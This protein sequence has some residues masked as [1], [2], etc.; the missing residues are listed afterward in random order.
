MS[1]AHNTDNRERDNGG[2]VSP[3]VPA[4]QIGATPINTGDEWSFST[5]HMQNKDSGFATVQMVLDA[6]LTP[7]QRRAA[8]EAARGYHRREPG[9]SASPMRMAL[10]MYGDVLPDLAG[11]EITNGVLVPTSRRTYAERRGDTPVATMRDDVVFP[12][13]AGSELRPGRPAGGLV[14]EDDAY[15]NQPP[16]SFWDTRD[17]TPPSQ[18]SGSSGSGSSAA[19]DFYEQAKNIRAEFGLTEHE[20]NTIRWAE[21]MANGMTPDE[22]RDGIRQRLSDREEA[23]DDAQPAVLRGAHGF[24]RDPNVMA[25]QVIVRWINEETGQVFNAPDPSWSPPN[26]DWRRDRQVSAPARTTAPTNPIGSSGSSGSGSSGSSG[27]TIRRDASNLSPAAQR[28]Q[29]IGRRMRQNAAERNQQRTSMPGGVNAG[30]LSPP[31]DNS[32]PTPGNI[33][34]ATTNNQH[35]GGILPRT[36]G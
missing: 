13:G 14:P 10:A 12:D 23:S 1:S 32:L 24:T 5:P 34:G 26:S 4:H 35:P 2:S 21:R 19:T 16:G 20:G 27:N 29:E 3:G 9:T 11:W 25:P 22:V 28:R 17:R 33:P 36:L 6:V 8:W 7:E 30:S 15:A 31:G 18:S